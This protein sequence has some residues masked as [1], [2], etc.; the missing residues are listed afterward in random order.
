VFDLLHLHVFASINDDFHKRMFREEFEF[1]RSENCRRPSNGEI[2][3]NHIN[4]SDV[5]QIVFFRGLERIG[6]GE[7]T[8]RF[9]LDHENDEIKHRFY[10]FHDNELV[11]EE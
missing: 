5:V 6:Q 1:E 7:Y 3:R 11:Y 4:I 2:Y 10:T 9:R 8:L